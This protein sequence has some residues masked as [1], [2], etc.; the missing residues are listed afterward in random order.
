VFSRSNRTIRQKFS[1]KL[2]SSVFLL[3]FCFFL[4]ACKEEKNNVVLDE[5]SWNQ[6]VLEPLFKKPVSTYE[7]LLYPEVNSL[8]QLQVATA[9]I[10]MLYEAVFDA[11]KDITNVQMTSQEGYVGRIDYTLKDQVSSDYS[12]LGC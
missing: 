3:F 12:G 8:E 6:K 1:K 4:V 10:Y 9:R 11:Y 7:S 2:L 5:K